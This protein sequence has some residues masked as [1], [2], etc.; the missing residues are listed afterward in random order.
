M[1]STLLQRCLLVVRRYDLT[2][3]LSQRSV[4]AGETIAKEILH[5]VEKTELYIQDCCRN[6]SNNMSAEAVV[7]QASIKVISGRAICMHCCRS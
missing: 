2:T 4:C 7:V 3:T 5:I 6:G 1:T